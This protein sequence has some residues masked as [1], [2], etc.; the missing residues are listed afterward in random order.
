MSNIF[1]S[2]SACSVLQG[3]SY[4]PSNFSSQ[5]NTATYFQVINSFLFVT[6]LCLLSFSKWFTRSDLRRSFCIGNCDT[7]YKV[8]DVTI[9]FTFSLSSG[10]HW[11]FKLVNEST[12][13]TFTCTCF[14]AHTIFLCG[15]FHARLLPDNFNVL[16]SCCLCKLSLN[17]STNDEQSF[18][19]TSAINKN[20]HDLTYYLNS[21]ANLVVV[22]NCTDIFINVIVYQFWH[23]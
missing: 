5:S 9:F 4:L 21:L 7:T 23:S 6:H 15:T 11:F 10:N 3:N 1:I 14:G 17:A 13:I 16:V 12:F 20:F 19:K 8:I 2:G 22:S 18:K